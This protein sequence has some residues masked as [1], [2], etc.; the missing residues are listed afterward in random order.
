MAMAHK[1]TDGSKLKPPSKQEQELA[2]KSSRLVAAILGKGKT[3]RLRVIG[4][5]EQEITVPISAMHMLADILNYMGK[6]EAVTL[7]PQDADLTTQQVADFLNVSRPF[8]VKLLE[9]QEIPHHRV[10]SHRRV[11]FRDLLVYREQS[12]KQRRAA[13]DDLAVEAQKLEMGY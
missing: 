2:E 3:A 4:D 9:G 12:M 10:G 5:G 7:V 11:Y 6:G 13:M 8:V 1:L